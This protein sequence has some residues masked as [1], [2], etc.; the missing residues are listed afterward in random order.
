MR[1]FLFCKEVFKIECAFY[2]RWVNRPHIKLRVA[3]GYRAGQC[4]S[5]DLNVS[6]CLVSF[7]LHGT[8]NITC[9]F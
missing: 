4:E 3:C 6:P 8:E 1:N 5:R 2:T 9:L 7:Q